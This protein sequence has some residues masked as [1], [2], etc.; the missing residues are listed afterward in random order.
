MK[1]SMNESKGKFV[2]IEGLD[3]SGKSTQ[4]KLLAKALQERGVD[5]LSTRE[6][7]RDGLVGQLI[8]KVVNRQ[9]KLPPIALQLLFVADRL[10]HLEKVVWPAIKMGKV[11]ICDRY[12]WS[13]VAYGSFAADRN[14]LVE[15]HK[16]CLEPDLTI[17]LDI[18]PQKAI[19]RL[20]IRG[21]K[22]TIFEK[23]DKMRKQADTY[24]WLLANNQAKSVRVTADQ[25]PEAVLSDIIEALENKKI[26]SG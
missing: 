25:A 18:D 11:V 19:Q 13:T 15:I 20:S 6:H 24:Y 10:D 5:V 16:Y 22:A 3:L 4:V 26:F 2:V 23:Q 17:Y 7:T 8:E 12:Y 21:E 14:W 1:K 9:G